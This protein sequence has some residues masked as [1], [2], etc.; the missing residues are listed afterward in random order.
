MKIGLIGLRKSGKTTI[1]N[2]LTRM[3]IAI[4]QYSSAKDEPNI[5]VTR[6]ADPRIT[7]LSE[8]YRP[9]KTTYATLECIDFGGFR[10][11]TGGEKKEVSLPRSLG[12]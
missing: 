5:A 1:F 2:A 10:N 12:S 3:D 9:K 6:V 11:N 7:F 8:M 4:D